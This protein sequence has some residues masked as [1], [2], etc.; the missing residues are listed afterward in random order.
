MRDAALVSTLRATGAIVLGKTNLHELS[1]GWTNN[2]LAFGAARNPYDPTR[3]PGG[4]SG[5]TPVAI[6]ARFAPLGVAE[7]T[8][9]SIRVPAA[10]CGITG[11][12]PTTGRYDTRGT[13]PICPLFDQIGPHARSVAD[14]TLFDTVAAGDR[15]PLPDHPASSS[16]AGLEPRPLRGVRLGVP[17]EYFWA[18]LDSEVARVAEAALGR[19]RA[20][21]RR[22]P[23]ARAA[24]GLS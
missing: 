22:T 12:R 4:S 23:P 2:N 10:L 14:L 8:E 7:D 18:T 11:F 9:G 16:G 15:H 1:A 5:G 21:G 3:I 17:R 24:A 20:A 6:A 19:L 13:A